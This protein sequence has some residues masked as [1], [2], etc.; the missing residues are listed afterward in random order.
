M[1]MRHGT[2]TGDFMS[3]F[4]KISDWFS[5]ADEPDELRREELLRWIERE[6]EQVAW[7]VLR[8]EEYQAMGWVRMPWLM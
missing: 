3:L 6:P 2:D 5:K 1:T 4:S 7:Y 8:L